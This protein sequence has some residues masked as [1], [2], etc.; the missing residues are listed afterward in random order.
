M[1]FAISDLIHM[2]FPLG[3]LFF[4]VIIHEISHGYVALLQGDHTAEQAGR[5]T[6]NPI[7]HFDFMGMVVLPLF[8]YW[9][10]GIPVGYAKPVPV[11]PYQLR[12]QRWGDLFV[13]AAGPLSNFLTAIIFAIVTRSLLAANDLLIFSPFVQLLG[14]IV[15]VNIGLTLLNLVPIPPIDGSKIVHA[16]LPFRVRNRLTN[17]GYS[18]RSY[19]SQYWIIALV[20]F[21]YFGGP[22]IRVIVTVLAPIQNALYSLL[23]GP[24]WEVFLR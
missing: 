24:Y 15:Q 9:S 10:F 20:L 12:N 14:Y 3:I 7:R 18:L 13:S 23:M 8:S 5:L 19:V 17:T 16:L 4:S 11:N 22:I 21:L 6:L 1:D 2:L